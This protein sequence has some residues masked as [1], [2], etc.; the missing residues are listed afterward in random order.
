MT[1]LTTLGALSALLFLLVVPAVGQPESE[2]S[3][4]R[5]V[6]L[7][8]TTE[9]ASL[10]AYQVEIRYDRSRVKIVSLEGGDPEAFRAPP[11]HDPAGKAGGRI[12]LAAL[13]AD[14][15]AA[16]RGRV[17][18]ARLHVFLE[19]ADDTLDLTSNLVTAARPGGERIA[20]KV[21][22]REGR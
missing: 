17:R 7:W 4:F 20:P 11:H 12:V 21:E 22:I 15:A 16:P 5:T 2:R 1:R 18:V 19:D 9:D 3:P 10:V 13:T 6:D 8:L 14:D